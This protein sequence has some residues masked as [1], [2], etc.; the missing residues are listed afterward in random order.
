MKFTRKNVFEI[1]QADKSSVQICKPTHSNGFFFHVFKSKFTGIFF[2]FINWFIMLFFWMCTSTLTKLREIM[3]FS[4]NLLFFLTFAVKL[5]L[6]M[7]Y[8]TI[9]CKINTGPSEATKKWGVKTQKWG[10]KDHILAEICLLLTNFALCL[11]K[12]GRWCN[13]HPCP[14]ASEDPETVEQ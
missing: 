5:P 4:K 14:P 1:Y 9:K 2:L 7:Q 13:W 6:I 11:V 10:D 8:G 3:V 12:F